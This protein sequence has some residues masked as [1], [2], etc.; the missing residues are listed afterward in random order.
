MFEIGDEVYLVERETWSQPMRHM[1]KDKV[2]IIGKPYKI[3]NI[4]H[5]FGDYIYQINRINWWFGGRSLESVIDRDIVVNWFK[6]I[7]GVK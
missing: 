7:T 2:L 1:L 6:S 5:M 4:G 3:T